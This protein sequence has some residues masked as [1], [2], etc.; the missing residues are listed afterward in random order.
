MINKRL[1]FIISF[2][3]IL[4]IWALYFALRRDAVR[5]LGIPVNIT[6]IIILIATV[7]LWVLI[8]FREK[9]FGDVERLTYDTIRFYYREIL[10]TF[11]LIITGLAVAVS[12]LWGFA[13][14]V[15]QTVLQEQTILLMVFMTY[16]GIS[17]SLT[18][19]KEFKEQLEKEKRI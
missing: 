10:A 6:L 18:I 9:V 3:I 13:S 16:I 17:M 8:V 19:F 2:G 5:V 7:S 1:C 14:E 11:G 4:C 12:V 15:G